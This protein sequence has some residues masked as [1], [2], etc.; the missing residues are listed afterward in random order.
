MSRFR[1]VA[2]ALTASL[3]ACLWDSDT[4]ID[5]MATLGFL[6]GA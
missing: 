4:F 5:K 1:F 3:M 2:L 6:K